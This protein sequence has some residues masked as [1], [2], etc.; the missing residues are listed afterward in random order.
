MLYIPASKGRALE[1]AASLAADAIIFDL[2]DAVA[3]EEKLAARATLGAV[4]GEIDYGRRLRLVRIN[5]LDT[6][7]GQEDA[8]A[9]ASHGSVDGIL[10][11]KVNEAADLA[12]V[13][14]LAPDKPL[15]AM[16]ETPL[17]ILNAVQ[18]AGFGSLRGLV[19][20]TNDLAKDLGARYRSDRAA[21]AA[22]L[23]FCLLAA[24]A[25]GR[26]IVDGVFNAFRDV[27][28]LEAESV[29]GRD[30]GFDG[31]TLIHPDQVAVANRVFAPSSEELDLAQRQ[32]A[33][34]NAALANGQGVAVL[35]G[36]IV[37][38]LHI[39][40]AQALIA[41]ARAIAVLQE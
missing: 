16:M 33:A 9:F 2:E 31:K 12:A 41:K 39:L 35:D 17:G 27:A 21:L 26:V 10:V 4:L 5:G 8:L 37:E 13:A 19:M 7:W 6:A 25:H 20:G 22:S 24:K 15:W 23:G 3:P 36:K 11:P 18:I 34:Y 29:Q 28:G 30:M 40:A 32:I 38:N 1:K 14:L